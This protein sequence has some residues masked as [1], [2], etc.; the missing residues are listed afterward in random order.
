[1]RGG[2]QNFPAHPF[3]GHE[4]PLLPFWTILPAARSMARQFFTLGK[5]G[6]LVG[7]LQNIR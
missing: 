7:R 2:F 6:L 3:F 4:G 5:I 1:L